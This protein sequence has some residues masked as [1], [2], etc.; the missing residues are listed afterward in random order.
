MFLL[1]HFFSNENAIEA[2]KGFAP[3]Y[4]GWNGTMMMTTSGVEDERKGKPDLMKNSYGNVLPP[5]KAH[6]K[7]FCCK[8]GR[9]EIRRKV[10]SRLQF[11]SSIASSAVTLINNVYLFERNKYL[12]D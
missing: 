12:V 9:S 10:T 4:F 6:D 5:R 7:Q 11:A 2:F 1:P 3:F 8:R